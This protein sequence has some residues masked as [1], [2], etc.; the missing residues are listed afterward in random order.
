[1]NLFLIIILSVFFSVWCLFIGMEYDKILPKTL[2]E[3]SKSEDA[4]KKG[5][6]ALKRL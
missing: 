5:K 2:K 4:Y 3:N 1:M 6:E